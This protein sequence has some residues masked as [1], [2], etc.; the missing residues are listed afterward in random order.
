MNIIMDQINN[1]K[2]SFFQKSPE[3]S[4]AES[5]AL[6]FLKGWGDKNL[7]NSSNIDFN[8][9]TSNVSMYKPSPCISSIKPT[10]RYEPFNF[11]HHGTPLLYDSKP[12][13]SIKLDFLPIGSPEI[14]F[15]IGPSALDYRAK[16]YQKQSYSIFER[17]TRINPEEKIAIKHIQKDGPTIYVSNKRVNRILKRRQKRVAFLMQNPEY[18]LPYK[19]RTKGPVHKSRSTSALN[20]RRKIDGRFAKTNGMM[21]DFTVSIDDLGLE[22][23]TRDDNL[24]DI[25][26][27][28]I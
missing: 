8:K 21:L 18:S 16:K 12:M 3:F 1:T 9:R 23:R 22:N 19:F 27:D 24:D 7:L 14:D 15:V 5:P 28:N 13:K 20:R 11:M 2:L 6:S 17:H 10:P 26:R 4:L 25:V